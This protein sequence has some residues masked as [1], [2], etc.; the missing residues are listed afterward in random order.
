VDAYSIPHQQHQHHPSSITLS[1]KQT[2]QYSI[3]VLTVMVMVLLTLNKSGICNELLVLIDGGPNDRVKLVNSVT[4]RIITDVIV[5]TGLV[6]NMNVARDIAKLIFIVD[7]WG[8][9][10]VKPEELEGTVNKPVILVIRPVNASSGTLSNGVSIVNAPIYRMGHT[11]YNATDISVPCNS[12]V[13]HTCVNDVI[14]TRC[15]TVK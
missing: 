3:N 7:H 6:I 1:D 9:F 14:F 4:P 13:P 2:E 12:T 5:F 10:N 8:A 15:G 11:L